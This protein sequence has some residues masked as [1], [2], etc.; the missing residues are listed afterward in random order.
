MLPD[1]QSTI[2]QL[3]SPDCTIDWNTDPVFPYPVQML[4][5]VTEKFHGLYLFPTLYLP[6][7]S[8]SAA[9]RLTPFP[10]L[11]TPHL[12]QTKLPDVISI[13]WT[14]QHPSLSLLKHPSYG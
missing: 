6:G 8:D 13:F 10:F 7:C 11:R 9:S 14:P 3:A 2:L 12:L 1:H 5:A 4:F